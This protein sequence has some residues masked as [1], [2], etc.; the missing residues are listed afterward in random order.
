VLLGGYAAGFI[1]PHRVGPISFGRATANALAGHEA[2][3]D[4]IHAADPTAFVSVPDYNCLLPVAGGVDWLPGKWFAERLSPV[5]TW[6]GKRRPR[7]MDF[8]AIHYYGVNHAFTDFPVSPERWAGR[9]DHLVKV[10]KAYHD[11]FGLPILIA[12]N[13]FATRDR[14][15][16]ADGWTRESYLVAHVKAVQEARAQGVP[17]IGYMY[18]TLTDNYEWGSYGPRFGLW[19]VDVRSGDYTRRPTPAV[20]VYREIVKAGGVSE[21]L[22]RKYPRP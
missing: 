5:T 7:A 21:E 10:L 16:R 6:N 1:P 11:A 8:A 20:A 15:P 12:E 2:A 14:A 19:E 9:P 17:V 4:A 22:A 18:W 3:Y 13:G